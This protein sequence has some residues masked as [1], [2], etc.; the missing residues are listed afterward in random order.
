MNT[1]PVGT[2]QHQRIALA[3]APMHRAETSALPTEVTVTL[4]AVDAIPEDI[5]VPHE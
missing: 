3:V 2:R 5:D 4:G 1:Q